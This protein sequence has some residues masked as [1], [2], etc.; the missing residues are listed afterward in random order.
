MV[1]TLKGLIGLGIALVIIGSTPSGPRAVT[2]NPK[3]NREIAAGVVEIELLD[4][5]TPEEEAALDRQ[6]RDLGYPEQVIRTT[7]FGI[8]RTYARLAIPY[9]QGAE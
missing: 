9:G 5:P 2:S 8:K 1:D 7:P 6:L 3:L 4:P